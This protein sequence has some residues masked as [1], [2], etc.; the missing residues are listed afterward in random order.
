MLPP[1]CPALSCQHRVPARVPLVSAGSEDGLSGCFAEGVT[2]NTSDSES[3][4]SK[5]ASLLLS[6]LRVC[7]H[8][9]LVLSRWCFCSEAVPSCWWHRDAGPAAISGYGVQD[10]SG[11]AAGSAPI[12]LSAPLQACSAPTAVPTHIQACSGGEGRRMLILDG[13]EHL[14]SVRGV[15]GAGRLLPVLT[16]LSSAL[17]QKD[18]RTLSCHTSQ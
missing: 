11:L 1:G 9:H 10:N 13:C 14:S 6:H 16:H 12:T 3:S 7:V 15:A 5:C 4:S 17:F 2:S 18:K 8:S